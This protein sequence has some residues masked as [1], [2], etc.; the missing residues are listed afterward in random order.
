MSKRAEE[1]ELVDEFAGLLCE[2]FDRQIAFIQCEEDSLRKWIVAQVSYKLLSQHPTLHA[3]GSWMTGF[4]ILM[5]TINYWV[6]E[7]DYP[8][9]IPEEM[10]DDNEFEPKEKLSKFVI[11][12]ID[13]IFESAR[14]YFNS[15]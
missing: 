3:D 4:D 14:E 1:K 15:E 5:D 8:F 13:E 10:I 11:D 7:D 12:H 2:E 6:D 9:T